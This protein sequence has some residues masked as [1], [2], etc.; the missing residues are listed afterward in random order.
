MVDV[1][2]TLGERIKAIGG[3]WA[4][5]ASV[6]SFVLYVFGYLALRFHLTALGIGTDLAVLDERY[7][8]AGARFLVYLAA[9]VPGIVLLG[10]LMLAALWLPCRLLPAAWRAQ[11]AQQPAAWAG[12]YP[13]RLLFVG[14]LFSVSLIQFVMKDCFEL[15][16]LLLR[17]HLP[18]TALSGWLLREDEG[19]IA[20]YFTG[21]IAACAVP[22]AVLLVVQGPGLTRGIA[23][24]RHLL[25]VLFALQVLLLPVNYGY[26]VLDNSLPRVAALDGTTPMPAGSSAWLVWEGKEGMTFLVRAQQAGRQT[27][28]L[29]TLGRAEVK[30]VEILAYERILPA[31]F[32]PLQEQ[33]P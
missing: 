15:S 18:E 22:A 11:L 29:I 7:L 12:T 4:A 33:R 9:T 20:L 32:A 2:Q 5:Y 14:I 19:R 13:G 28:S 23:T 16:N 26:L 3:S 8:F 21:L 17:P 25:V 27:R 31:L 24:A 1:L 30:R 10:L 6:G